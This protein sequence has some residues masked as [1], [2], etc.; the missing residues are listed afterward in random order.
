MNIDIEVTFKIRASD[1]P[2]KA[3][4]RLSIL[5]TLLDRIASHPCVAMLLRE[6]MRQS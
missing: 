4:P 1:E 6:I 2:P 5:A 3:Q